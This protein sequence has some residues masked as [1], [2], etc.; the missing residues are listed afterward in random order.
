MQRDGGERLGGWLFIR[1]NLDAVWHARKFDEA[2]TAHDYEV[3]VE[4]E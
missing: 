3:S 4:T 2:D 1:K